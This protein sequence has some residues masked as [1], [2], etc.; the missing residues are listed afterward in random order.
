VTPVGQSAGQLVIENLSRAH[1]AVLLT[2]ARG[3]FADPRD[4][5][6]VVAE[7]LVRAWRHHDQF[8]PAR[9]SERAW[10]FGIARNTAVDH[11]RRSRRHLGSTLVA[12]PVELAADDI[13]LDRLVESS[14][15][16]DALEALSD[17][18]RA[19]LIEAYYNGRTTT[20]I[21]LRHHL[22]PGTVKSRLYYALRAMRGHLEERGVVR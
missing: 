15:V 13:D 22:P 12:E 2:W 3:R 9:G 17:E 11:H 8:D 14:H 18:H 6:E 20:Q 4:A 21:A 7:T 5:E 16:R 1:S 10:L 19:A